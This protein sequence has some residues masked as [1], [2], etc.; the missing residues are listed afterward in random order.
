MAGRRVTANRCSAL[1]STAMS[2]GKIW[3]QSRRSLPRDVQE[4]FA[5]LLLAFRQHLVPD[6]ECSVV[7]NLKEAK[8]EIDPNLRYE[9]MNVEKAEHV[10]ALIAIAAKR[11]AEKEARSKKKK[12][13]NPEEEEEA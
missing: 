8:V 9:S 11:I 5:D 7:V 10:E 13:Q 2:P 4:P 3:R 1:A 12:T 6:P